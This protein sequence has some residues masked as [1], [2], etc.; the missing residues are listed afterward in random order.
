MQTNKNF[1]VYI[2]DD[3]SPENLFSIVDEYKSRVDLVYHRFENNMGG[4]DLVGQWERCVGLTRDEPWIWLFSDDDVLEECCVEEFFKR[5]ERQESGE[6]YHFNVNVIDECGRIISRT[7]FPPFLTAKEF[8]IGK[9]RGQLKSYVVEYIFSRRIYEQIGGFSKYD[10]AWNADD[11]TWIK[12][13][14][15]DKIRTIDGAHVNWRKSMV[16]ISPNARDKKIVNRK[17]DADLKY[18]K[19]VSS[20]FPGFIYNLRLG[21]SIVTWFCVNMIKYSAVVSA[22]E[23]KERIMNCLGILNMRFLTPLVF[24][25][26]EKKRRKLLK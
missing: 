5:I 14:M 6:L 26:L 13:A 22:S 20:C 17:I 24:L 12:M 10:M 25:Y 4:V 9:F 2:G 7:S 23:Q 1:T 21:I 3:C 18:I 8:A 15:I 19:F 16:N 11:A